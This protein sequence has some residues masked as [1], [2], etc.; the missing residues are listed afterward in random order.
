VSFQFPGDGKPALSGIDLDLRTFRRY[1][2]VVPQESVLF[3]G[4]IAE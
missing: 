4:A 2:S 1:V 3:E